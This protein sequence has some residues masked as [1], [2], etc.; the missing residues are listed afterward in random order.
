MARVYPIAD[1]DLE[2][3][4]ADKTSSVHFMRYELSPAMITA[5]K[6]GAA[7]LAGIDHPNYPVEGFAVA[8]AV[9]D[10]LASDLREAAVN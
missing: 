1:E 10:S 7:I 4:T 9:R 2:R 3:A 5:A 6:H 8:E